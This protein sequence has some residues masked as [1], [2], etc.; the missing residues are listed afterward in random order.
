MLILSSLLFRNKVQ[1]PATAALQREFRE[2]DKSQHQQP[3]DGWG[4][5]G[6]KS[7]ARVESIHG[8]KNV[9]GPSQEPWEQSPGLW[10]HEFPLP[11][12]WGLWTCANRGSKSAPASLG[13]QPPHPCPHPKPGR[14][15]WGACAI[16]WLERH[17][18]LWPG[19]RGQLGVGPF[20]DSDQRGQS[21]SGS[22]GVSPH[23]PRRGRGPRP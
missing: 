23:R 7:G 20:R 3:G 13:R 2:S 5:Q 9:P 6:R 10:T 11:V 21:S 19:D 18:H 16:S 8:K 15:S 17:L 14:A 1:H 4:G 12:S 22:A